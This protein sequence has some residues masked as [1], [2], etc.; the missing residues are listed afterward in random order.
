MAISTCS[1]DQIITAYKAL[2][3]QQHRTFGKGRGLGGCVGEKKITTE[4]YI[5]SILCTSNNEDF[6]ALNCNINCALKRFFF[7]GGGEAFCSS[8]NEVCAQ[9]WGVGGGGII[10]SSL[11][12]F[13]SVWGLSLP[14]RACPAMVFYMKSSVGDKVHI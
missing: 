14:I 9:F 1:S 3:S 5:L 12:S 11:N 7:L 4:F 6:N 13:V 8:F 10:P 2:T